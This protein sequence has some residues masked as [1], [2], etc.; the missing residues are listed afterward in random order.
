MSNLYDLSASR[1]RIVIVTRS[2]PSK[3]SDLYFPP[4][5]YDLT[6]SARWRAYCA[7]RDQLREETASR[8]QVRQ[9]A[10]LYDLSRRAHRKRS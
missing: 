9:P 4:I 3:L 7:P 1:T 8:S 10:S 5:A 2:A 6:A